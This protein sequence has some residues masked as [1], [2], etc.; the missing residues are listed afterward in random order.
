MGEAAEWEI[1]RQYGVDISDEGY[2]DRHYNGPRRRTSPG[3][4]LHAGEGNYEARKYKV[5]IRERTRG[6]QIVYIENGTHR[7]GAFAV[8]RQG[9]HEWYTP[10]GQ[11]SLVVELAKNRMTEARAGSHYSM[12]K[13]MIE[14]ALDM[15]PG[16]GIQLGIVPPGPPVGYENETY[17][18]ET[19]VRARDMENKS[20]TN[21]R[22]A[23]ALMQLHNGARLYGVKFMAEGF[24]KPEQKTYTYKDTSGLDLAMLDLVVVEARDSFAI[25][26]IVQLNVSPS[27]AAVELGKVRHIVS[28]IDQVAHG[29]KLGK[30]NEAVER[31]AMA[32]VGERLEKFRQQ[33]GHTNFEAVRTML[34]GP[35]VNQTIDR[36]TVSVDMFHR[37]IDGETGEIFG[38]INARGMAGVQGYID[39]GFFYHGNY[40]HAA[41]LKVYPAT[42]ANAG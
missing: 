10:D 38:Q 20:M 41:R 6:Y 29:A 37:L 15:T 40:S 7:A 22:E 33:L 13:G 32:E 28:K 23:I 18:D 34:G 14:N 26:Q 2:L 25:A 4:N 35:V 42:N 5:S 19:E 30:E 17:A 3:R 24:V 31:L 27:A 21:T 11:K 39:E 9:N 1:F 8:D 12:A 16:R 36:N